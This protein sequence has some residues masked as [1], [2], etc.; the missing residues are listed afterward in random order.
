MNSFMKLIKYILL[1]VLPVVVAAC[2]GNDEPEPDP[3]A[4]TMTLVYMVSDNSLGSTFQSDED[5]LTQMRSAAVRGAMNGGGRL[6]IYRDGPDGYPS[7]FEI[8]AAGDVV[9]QSYTSDVSSLTVDR[10]QCVINDA[11]MAAPAH[12]YGL[13]LW[14]HGTGWIESSSSRSS[15][16]P[17]MVEAVGQSFGQDVHPVNTEMKITTLATALRE[18]PHDFIYFDCCFMASV[19]VLY[20]LRDCAKTFVAYG[21]EIPIEG[22]PY[23]VNTELLVA[24]DIDGVQMAKNTLDYYLNRASNSSCAIAVVDGSALDNLAAATRA[25]MQTGAVASST[26]YGVPFFRSG[27]PRTYLYD[28]KDYIM[29]LE[30]DASLL[31]SW[32]QAY[33]K[34]VVYSGA[35]AYS[36]GLDMSKYSGL[37]CHIVRTAADASILG[38]SN[39]SWWSDVVKYNP[40]VSQ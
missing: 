29:G 4:P 19:E 10:M 6:L 17:T 23:D 16:D 31:A 37:G 35:T 7:L 15:D 11:R 2:S 39:Q 33:D 30:V 9:I 25:V 36:Y 32:R 20:E 22:M 1:A 38:Y 24:A 14:S 8:T 13:V 26:Y 40:S 27:G 12:Q 34:A 21:T 18:T 28:M 5:N 3:F